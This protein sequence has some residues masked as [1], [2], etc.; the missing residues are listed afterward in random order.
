M[1]DAGWVVFIDFDGTITKEDVCEALVR[2]FAAEGWEEINR[3]WEEKKLSTLDC[4]I[5]T[6][7][8][9]KTT[10]P[11]DFDK[12]IQSISVDPYFKELIDFCHAKGIQAYILSDGYDYNIRK[13][14]DREE[15]TVPFFANTLRLK[16]HLTVE[17]PYHNKDCGLCGVCKKN[18]MAKLTEPG[19]R[20]IYL[21]DG[22]SDLCASQEADHIFAKGRLYEYCK[23]Q[24][25]EVT[26]LDSFEIVIKRLTQLIAEG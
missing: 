24:G 3:L 1:A 13:I 26:Y 8:L 14:L 4:A 17:V 5:E 9:F 18:L 20:S 2:N 25:K 12:L 15:V 23:E 10:E 11:E 21:G 7:K 19:Q 22:Y 16:P 6:F